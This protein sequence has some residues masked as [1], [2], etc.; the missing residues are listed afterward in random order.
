MSGKI[1]AFD[2][3]VSVLLVYWQKTI[4]KLHKRAASTHD[5]ETLKLCKNLQL[6]PLHV[7]KKMLSMYV[8]ECRV[9]YN[10]AFMQWRNIYAF[11]PSHYGGKY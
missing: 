8:Y 2:A 3:K 10:I 4:I 7:K 5:K 1:M 6:V 9:L 11:R